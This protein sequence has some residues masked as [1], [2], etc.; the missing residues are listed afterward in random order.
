MV[1]AMSPYSVNGSSAL[2]VSSVSTDPVAA[3]LP[4]GMNP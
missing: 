2:E 4:L 3:A 1:S